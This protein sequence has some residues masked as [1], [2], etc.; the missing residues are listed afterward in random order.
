MSRVRRALIEVRSGLAGVRARIP[1][2]PRWAR[3]TLSVLAAAYLVFLLVMN[4]LLGTGLFRSLANANE[5]ELKIEYS[6]AYSLFPG[7]VVAKD[8]TVRF[9]DANVQFLLTLEDATLD[10]SLPALTRKTFHVKRVEADGVSFLLRM[11]TSS[12]EGKE[13]RLAAYPQIPGYSDPPLTSEEEDPPIPEDQYGLWTVHLEEVSA[14]IREVWIMEYRYRGPGAVAGGFRLRPMREL[15]VSPSVLLT[16]GGTVSIGEA[17]LM[18][19]SEGR[20]EAQ[21]EA[22]DV[23]VPTGAE[24]LR[25]VSV[26]SSLRGELVSLSP[27]GTTYLA[28]TDATLAGGGGPLELDV[29][30][31]HGV[32]MPGTRIEYRAAE[33][34]VERGGLT[35]RAGVDASIAVDGER[36]VARA[37]LPRATLSVA[38]AEAVFMTGAKGSITSTHADLA[39]PLAI[40]AFEGAV[41]SARA[42]DLAKLQT[43]MPD[44]LVLRG[45]SAGLAVRA[46]SEGGS[47]EGRAD[48]SLNDARVT[49]KTLDLT[50]SG[51]VW[52]NASS[53]DLSKRIAL[54][55]TGA[56]LDRIAIGVEGARQSGL[57]ATV[58]LADA[59]LGRNPEI[60]AGGVALDVRPGDRVMRFAAEL[61]SLPRWVGDASA[62]KSLRA[63]ASAHVGGGTVAFRDVRASSGRLAARGRFSQKDGATHG[64]FVLRTGP[65]S[66]GLALD[67]DGTRVVPFATESW[68]GEGHR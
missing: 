43:A 3:V 2:M 42:P 1:K 64:A 27:I 60:L 61:A 39:A 59:T 33:A 21:V 44:G 20:L 18:R 4:V 58:R 62:S 47:L 23:R 26:R 12:T 37:G 22:F 57:Q 67:K 46:R 63:Q 45:G 53:K 30:L 13:A 50:A 24:V 34:R 19:A 56:D 35:V 11:K 36:I 5:E 32:L 16:Q 38:G 51:K 54:P 8:L 6:S 9:Q 31:D 10:V 48:L 29:N 28:S 49:A 68:L 25:H 40:H 17:E 14:S 52:A 41:P 15:W 55:D 65:L 7:H 66:V